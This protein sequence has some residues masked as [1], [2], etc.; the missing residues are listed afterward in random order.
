MRTDLK[1]EVP[2]REAEVAVPWF[3]VVIGTSTSAVPES[4]AAL[5]VMR[6][7]QPVSR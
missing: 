5:F 3:P 1:F 7:V 6:D 4:M 2:R